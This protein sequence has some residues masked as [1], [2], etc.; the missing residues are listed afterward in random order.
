M[1]DMVE[2]E[3]ALDLPVSYMARTRAWYAALGYSPYLW[4]R[5][6]AVP[7]APPP[8]LKRAR[9]ALVTTAAPFRPKLGE[10]GPGAPYNAAAKFYEVWSM[11][12]GVDP[13]LRIAHVAVD[14]AHWRVADQGSYLPFD[15][16]RMAEAEG[17]IGALGPRL[18]GL[19]TNRSQRM[20]RSVDCPDLVARLVEDEANAVILV[21]NC[22]VCH[23]SVALAAR[24]L[25]AAG[26]PTVIMAAARDIPEHVG[27]PRMVWSDLPLGHA[28]GR[29]SDVACQRRVLALALD[30]LEQASA[31][32]TTVT[33]GLSWPGGSVWKRDYM[34]PSLLSAAELAKRRA[35]FAAQKATA[36]TVREG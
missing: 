15:A 30:L 34:N 32:R 35:E 1:T 19:P 22:P 31:P 14:R 33:S 17:R 26:L 2:M 10:Q 8:R 16:L 6:E 24:A 13:D 4:A 11:P 25:E 28:A 3:I 5:E 23:Q 12:S 36:R 7:F 27:V 9:V 18:H 20:T 21:P 29:P